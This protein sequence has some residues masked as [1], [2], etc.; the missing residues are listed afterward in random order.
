LTALIVSLLYQPQV[1]IGIYLVAGGA[2]VFLLGLLLAV[3]RDRLVALPQRIA[4]REG[5]FRVIGW[6]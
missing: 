3:Y 4:N 6:R 5:V 1:A 2:V